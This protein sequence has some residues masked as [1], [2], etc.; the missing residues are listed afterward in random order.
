MDYFKYATGL[1]M[2]CDDKWQRLFGMKRRVTEDAL[3]QTEANLALAI[4]SVTEEIV[5]KLAKT[6]INGTKSANLVMAGGVALNGVVNGKLDAL[7]EIE[8]LWTQPA[9]GDAGGALGAALAT[10]HILRENPK[11]QF[12][13]AMY[14]ALL[15]PAFTSAHIEALLQSYPHLIF[16]KYDSEALLLENSA[17]ALTQGKIVGWFQGR[18]EFGP[19]ALGNRSILAD[20]RNPDMQQKINQKSSLERDFDLLHPVFWKKMLESILTSRIHRRICCL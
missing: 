15:E 3:A 9:A 4:Q 8:N 7:P 17:L 20:P 13:D 19:R 18:M 1:T 10:W 16:K 6:A 12:P 14:G 5:L 2:T 11:I